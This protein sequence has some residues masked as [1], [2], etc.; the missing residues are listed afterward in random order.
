MGEGSGQLGLGGKLGARATSWLTIPG[1]FPLGSEEGTQMAGGLQF[2]GALPE[3]PGGLPTSS[4]YNRHL[5]KE[6]QR[7]MR[8]QRADIWESALGTGFRL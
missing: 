1:L 6:T 4:S 7:R 3:N 8:L 2:P 5:T